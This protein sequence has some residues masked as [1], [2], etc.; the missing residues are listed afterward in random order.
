MKEE[1]KNALRDIEKAF[2][3]YYG[4]DNIENKEKIT[5]VF[6]KLRVV[7]FSNNS[8]IDADNNEDELKVDFI[9]ANDGTTEFSEKYLKKLHE[10]LKCN[11]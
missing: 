11:P 7:G 10:I 4:E 6:S 8:N 5:R 9:V 1:I 3:I 2:I